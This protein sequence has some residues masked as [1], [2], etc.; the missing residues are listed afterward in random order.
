MVKETK[1]YDI[2]EV[3]PNATETELKKAYRK[4]ALKYHPDK[5]PDEGERFKLISQAYEILSDSS[6]REIYDKYGEEGVKEGG[7]GG[8][9]MHNPMDI[10]N[11]FFGGGGGGRERETKA[12]DTIHSL[13]VTL[14]QLYNGAT[15]KM[16]LSR[17]VICK[18]C[19]G[20]GGEGENSVIK[21]QR[22]DGHGIEVQRVQI[23]PGFIQTAQRRCGGCRGE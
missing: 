5:N 10:F 19:K 15:R 16:K 9:G 6:K 21:C 20:K 12:K 3:K 22:C 18:R 8:G 17:D 23:A 11:M 7:G 1:L 2:L 4:L 13:S 14:E